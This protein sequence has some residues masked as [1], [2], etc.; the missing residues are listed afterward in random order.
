M[1]KLR[2]LDFNYCLNNKAQGKNLRAFLKLLDANTAYLL[3]S[4]IYLFICSLSIFIPFFTLFQVVFSTLSP[5]SYSCNIIAPSLALLLCQL[6][7][8]AHNMRHCLTFL[9]THSC[10][11]SSITH[12]MHSLYQGV[13]LFLTFGK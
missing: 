11:M 2:L 4:L 5:V 6:F 8:F 13:Y 9:A 10:N 7:L 3:F 1:A 12:S